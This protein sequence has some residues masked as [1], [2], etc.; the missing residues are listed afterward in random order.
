MTTASELVSK[1]CAMKKTYDN[2]RGYNRSLTNYC[3]NKSQETGSHANRFRAAI[4]AVIRK[5]GGDPSILDT[6]TK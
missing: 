4:K 2:I 3:K 1:F 5:N 6:N